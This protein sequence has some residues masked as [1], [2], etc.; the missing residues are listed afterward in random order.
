MNKK[1]GYEMF[2]YRTCGCVKNV[3]KVGNQ[4]VFNIEPSFPYI[5]DMLIDGGKQ[6]SITLIGRRLIKT[7]H[8]MQEEFDVFAVLKSIK[9]VGLNVPINM[10]DGDYH[11]FH[12]EEAEARRIRGSILNPNTIINVIG[13][14]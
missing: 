11:E 8:G 4:V 9:F 2:L 14:L 12:V 3:N 5:S 10:N 7:A 1:H 13:I 6:P